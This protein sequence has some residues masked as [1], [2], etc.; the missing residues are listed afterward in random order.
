MK[1]AVKN[2]KTGIEELSNEVAVLKEVNNKKPLENP[3]KQNH[4]VNAN[5]TTQT[6]QTSYKY[7]TAEDNSH[8]LEEKN[9]SVSTI[10]KENF[11]LKR[12]NKELNDRITILNRVIEEVLDQ[13]LKAKETPWE[14][15]HKDGNIFNQNH[16]NRN[17]VKNT[18]WTS[19]DTNRYE[20][21][22]EENFL[23]NDERKPKKT[24]ASNK[25]KQETYSRDRGQPQD[26][27]SGKRKRI[28]IVG[29]SQL[30]GIDQPRMSSKNDI[31]VRSQGG[32]RVQRLFDILDEEIQHKPE[33]VI[34]HVG[35]N[36]IENDNVEELIENFN[37]ISNVYAD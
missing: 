18:G 35:V 37:E 36:N 1:T 14:Q 28:L 27:K 24:N 22:S 23:H 29:D 32:L 30:H 10:V 9:T 16:M 21:L 25:Q 4:K 5:K 3:P 2:V 12:E 8:N 6:T 33:E 31:K 20:V 26:M 7:N 11:N 17:T 34:V 15:V 13:Q 19:V